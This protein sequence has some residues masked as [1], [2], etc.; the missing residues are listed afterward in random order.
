MRLDAEILELLDNQAAASFM[1][2]TQYV[3]SL[4]LEQQK[5]RK[6]EAQRNG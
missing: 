6:K 3:K 2:R 5:K 1:N 4:V